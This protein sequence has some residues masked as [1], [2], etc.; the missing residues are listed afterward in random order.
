MKKLHS[1][2]EIEN[3]MASWDNTQDVQ[4]N[5][6]LYAKIRQRLADKQELVRMVWNPTYVKVGVVA[7]SVL[8]LLNLFTF[9]NVPEQENTN[10][11]SVVSAADEYYIGVQTYSY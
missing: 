2:P 9:L 10:S 3:T 4:V 8:M 5:P 6:Y 1:H 11:S 7:M